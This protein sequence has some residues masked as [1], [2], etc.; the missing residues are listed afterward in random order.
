MSGLFG[1]SQM[2]PTPKTVRMPTATDP[3][4]LAA[5]QR[6]RAAALQR[7]GRLSTILT[8][9]TKSITGSSGLKLGA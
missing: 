6:T 2:P 8:D 5:A 1:K 7:K 4:I 9:Q 3:D